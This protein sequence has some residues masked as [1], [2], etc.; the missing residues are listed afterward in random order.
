[1]SLRDYYDNDYETNQA[2]ILDF[3]DR[4]VHPAYREWQVSGE[5]WIQAPRL[6]LTYCRLNEGAR[7]AV[8]TYIQEQLGCRMFMK[9]FGTYWLGVSF[10][11]A[12]NPR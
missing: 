7:W 8:D 5:N 3:Y 1:M 12:S 2:A 6:H 11:Y 4:Y 10:L 9:S